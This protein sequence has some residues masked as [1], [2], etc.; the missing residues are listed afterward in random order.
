MIQLSWGGDRETDLNALSTDEL[1]FKQKELRAAALKTGQLGFDGLEFHFGH[2]FL[3]CKLLD[4]EANRRTDLFGGNAKRRVSIV[5]DII[6]ELRAQNGD[7]FIFA[8]RMGAYLPTLE[9]GQATARILEQSGIDLLNITFSMVAPAEPPANFPLSG[10]VYGGHLIKQ[11]VG[12]PVIGVGGLTTGAKVKTLLENDYA[13]LAG[14]A[15]GILADPN[16]SAKI[17]EGLP[18]NECA[19]CK[20][21]L[22]FTDH[23]KCPAR[24]RAQ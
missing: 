18:V 10:M 5:S 15:R 17:L 12:I 11:A 3:L 14:V 13:D 2:G 8:L 1:L 6:P 22:W 21:C 16:F 19:G 24:R 23:A 4:A 20:E 9:A 7:A